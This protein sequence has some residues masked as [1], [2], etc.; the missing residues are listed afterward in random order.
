MAP[1]S[2]GGV[3][4][5]RDGLSG[6]FPLG[7]HK[8]V[9]WSVWPEGRKRLSFPEPSCHSPKVAFDSTASRPR[10]RPPAAP[11]AKQGAS[12]GRQT[13]HLP[14]AHLESDPAQRAAAQGDTG[15][16]VRV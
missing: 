16:D 6:E 10:P 9:L 7:D 1:E 8:L 5:E 15:T 12:S 4:G 13:P 3:Q 14:V 11:R 2:P